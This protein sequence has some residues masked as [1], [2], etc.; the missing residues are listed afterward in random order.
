M[1]P[2][3]QAALRWLFAPTDPHALGLMRVSLGLLLIGGHLFLWPHLPELLGPEAGIPFSAVQ[4]W[5]G[6]HRHSLYNLCQTTAQA[7]ALH[8]A[9]LVIFVLLTLGWRTRLV[10]ILALLV[11]VSVHQRMPWMQHGGDRLL[12][13]WTLYLCLVPSGAALSV[14]AWIRHRAGRPP[15]E[16]PALAHRLVQLQLCLMYLMT[17]LAKAGGGHWL[18]GTALYWS[19]AAPHF[20]RWP[21]LS[22][23]LVHSS[24]AQAVLVGATFATLAWEA[25]F[26]VLVWIRRARPWVLWG[27]VFVHGGIFLLMTVGSFSPASLWGYLA[28]LDQ[29]RLGDLGRRV[30][31]RLGGPW[32]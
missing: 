7:H 27:G 24:L 31:A 13:V 11:L 5:S 14:D 28:F 9:G 8:A 15:P 10:S 18:G 16:V 23:A 17:A 21:D 3:P 26:P 19:L 29:R 12:R 30:E 1:S 20:Q 25:A 4:E 6:R 2:A 22:E 32:A